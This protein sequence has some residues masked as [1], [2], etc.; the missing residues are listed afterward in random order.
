[1]EC[2]S[3]LDRHSRFFDPEE[4]KVFNDDTHRRYVGI[5]VMIRKSSNALL[6]EFSRSQLKKKV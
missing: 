1:M 3:G 2:F 6:P 5:G 4:Y